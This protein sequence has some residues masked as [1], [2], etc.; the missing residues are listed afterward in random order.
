MAGVTKSV[1][2]YAGYSHKRA[3]LIRPGDHVVIACV[4]FKVTARPKWVEN[5]K[6]GHILIEGRTALGRKTSGIVYR[7]D[8]TV[9]YRPK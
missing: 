8:H 5:G 2:E 9:M 1:S 4:W 7:W 3:D 6:G